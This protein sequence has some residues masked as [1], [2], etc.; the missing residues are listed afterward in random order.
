MLGT[1]LCTVLRY[2]RITRAFRVQ[3]G[4]AAWSTVLKKRTVQDSD[5]D[6]NHGT[7]WNDLAN[8]HISGRINDIDLDVWPVLG[9]A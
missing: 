7:T 1:R 8:V 3:C 6:C 9:M 5:L 4:P 2:V